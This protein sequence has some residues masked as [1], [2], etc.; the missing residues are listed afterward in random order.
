MRN[1]NRIHFTCKGIKQI[2]PFARMQPQRSL[3]IEPPR[4]L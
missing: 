3:A 2:L 1:V 4:P